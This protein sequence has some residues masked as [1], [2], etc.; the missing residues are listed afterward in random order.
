[1]A[2]DQLLANPGFTVNKHGAVSRG[3]LAGGDQQAL[4][5][6]GSADDATRTGVLGQFDLEGDVFAFELA[7]FER[8][9]DD[10]PHI[11]DPE[12]LFDIEKRPRAHRLDG[13]AGAGMGGN[14][15]DFDRSIACLDRA[16]QTETIDPRHAQVGQ[17]QLIRVCLEQGRR[18]RRISRAV[19]LPALAAEH[20]H[21]V[22]TGNFLVIDHQYSCFIRHAGDFRLNHSGP[23][24][25]S[26]PG[27]RR[28]RVLRQ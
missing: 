10:F 12:G 20:M 15:D 2:G 21:Q 3:D 16:Q 26:R 6:S 17:Y 28:P 13:R 18:L 23:G 19:D 24:H 7:L 1:M 25:E 14:H 5:D 27:F 22:L 11:G 4:H 8:F 9:M